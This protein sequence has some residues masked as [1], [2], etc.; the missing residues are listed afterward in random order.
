MAGTIKDVAKLAGVSIATVS[1]VLTGISIP[2]EVVAV[3][4]AV[5]FFL[6][7]MNILTWKEAQ[8]DIDWGG[9]VLIAAG[10]SLGMII[11]ETGAARWLAMAAFS[12][13]G[14][15]GMALRIFFAVLIV[16]LL[17]VFFSSNTVT[18]VILI[19]MMIAFSLSLDINPWYLAG[20]VAIAT[21][22]AFLLVTSS[23]TNVIPYSSGYFSISDFTRAGI[24]LTLVI[25]FCITF[26]F[27]VFAPLVW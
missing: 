5:A 25:P 18:G 14:A 3:A 13:I 1:H 22:M 12:P 27:M 11:F 7:G 24:F 17:K 6:P 26:A 4:A 23:P 2:I 10:L 20:P 16:E 21:S 8:S 19:P 9:I 15:L